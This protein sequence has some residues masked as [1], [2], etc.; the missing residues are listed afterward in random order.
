MNCL[1]Q[2]QYISLQIYSLRQLKSWNRIFA[3]AATA[4]YGSVELVGSNLIAYRETKAHL[5]MNGLV[6]PSAHVSLLT[7]RHRT[8]S[9]LDA[10]EALGVANLIVSSVPRWRRGAQAAFW[11]RTGAML[12]NLADRVARSPG[13]QLGYH[14]H[15]WDFRPLR[16]HSTPIETLFRAG[17]TG[18]LQWQIDLGWVT[19]S[20]QDV[21]V[22]LDK[23]LCRINSV[24]VREPAETLRHVWQRCADAGAHTM[25][26]EPDD[27]SEPEVICRRA[28]QNLHKLGFDSSKSPV[29]G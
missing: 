25:I 21:N 26:V 7:L 28:L 11:S 4:G 10:C 19:Q 8:T 1:S 27:T 2:P 9:I 13:L 5:R 15:G 16:D 22:W 20:G 17:S 14:N 24:H 6:A 3:A 12:K 23:D 29:R 18:L